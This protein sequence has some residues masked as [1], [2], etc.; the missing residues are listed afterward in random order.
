MRS[1]EGLYAITSADICIDDAHLQRAVT[2]ALRGGARLL[3][4]RDKAGPPSARQRRAAWLARACRDAG[5]AFIVN[6]DVALAADVR[7]DGVHVGRSDAAIATARAALGPAAIIGASC[8][9][10]LDYAQAAVEAGASYVAFGRLFP[11]RTKPL[12]PPARLDT[13]RTAVRQLAV[14]VCA[15]GGIGLVELPLVLST[16]VRLVAAVD[17]VFGA[18][19]IEAAAR[20]YADRLATYN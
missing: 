7:A 1:L 4:Y 13:L 9:D 20:A 11:S 18:A 5:C 8:G 16:G 6:D 12:A 3:Q 15:I 14:P 19:D 2:A 10:D 17:G